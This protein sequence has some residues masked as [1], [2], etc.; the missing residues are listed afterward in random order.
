MTY[1][2]CL[3]L[4]LCSLA[5]LS[6]L[7]Q[8]KPAPRTTLHLLLPA[9]RARVLIDGK[10]ITAKNGTIRD[11]VAPPLAAGKKE[12]VVTAVW[13][14]ND[15]TR[16]SRTR[17]V[18]PRIGEKVIVDL[19]KPDPKNPDRIEIRYVPTPDE[20][21][22]RMCKLARV[23]KEDVVFDLGC[24][25]GRIVIAAVVDFKAKKGVG[26]D[27]D[28]V[29]IRES[30]ASAKKYGARDRVEF[31][32]GDVLKIKDLSSASVVML[33]MGDEVNL[34]LRPILQK[35]LRP[36]ARIVSHRF[37]MGDWKPDKTEIVLGFDEEEYLI[38]LWT[39]KKK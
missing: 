7:A 10:A 4:L 31:R 13:R 21:V 1:I 8:D 29:R 16:F 3:G 33:Y 17:K 30:I 34:K 6:V 38:H 18:A 5:G 15:Y 24:G 26:I 25:D 32:V 36:G 28:P 37:G 23:N 22:E 19:R 2:R 20:V 9:R 14:S 27:L 35:T 12:Y 11:V 39:I